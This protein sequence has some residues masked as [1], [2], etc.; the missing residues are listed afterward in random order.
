MTKPSLQR[1]AEFIL[2]RSADALIAPGDTVT[3][4]VARGDDWHLTTTVTGSHELAELMLKV[5][6]TANLIKDRG[7]A[8]SSVWTELTPDGPVPPDTPPKR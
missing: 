6:A 7:P 1:L 2:F 5:T 4:V 8:V 3:I